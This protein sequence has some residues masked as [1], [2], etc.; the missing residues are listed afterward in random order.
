MRLKHGQMNQPR[1]NMSMIMAGHSVWGDS[2]II[3]EGIEIIVP[4]RYHDSEG[5]FKGRV[6]ELIKASRS[7]PSALNELAQIEG[8]EVR[9]VA[10]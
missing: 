3:R 8:I 9:R 2:K 7:E 10:N 6:K 4:R 1:R 5:C